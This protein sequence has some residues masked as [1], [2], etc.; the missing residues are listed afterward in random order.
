MPS[1]NR[2]S[3]FNTGFPYIGDAGRTWKVVH[4]RTISVV[5]TSGSPAVAKIYF[6]RGF[7]SGTNGWVVWGPFNTA[8]TTPTP[9]QTTPNYTGTLSAI[10]I[11][12]VT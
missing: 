7:D 8:L 5:A 4:M 2:Q 12:Y 6:M 3:N 11:V 9:T 1:V 10:N